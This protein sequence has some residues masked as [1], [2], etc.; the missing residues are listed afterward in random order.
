MRTSGRPFHDLL[1]R[2]GAERPRRVVDVGCGSGALTEL[3][4]QRWPDA[5]VEGFD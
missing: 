2:V 3:L 5:A 4:A 1:A